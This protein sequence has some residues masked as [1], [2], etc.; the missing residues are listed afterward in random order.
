MRA[1]LTRVIGVAAVAATALLSVAGAASAATHP[2][3]KTPTTLSIVEAKTTINQG[4]TDL[5]KGTLL[6]G[7]KPV[8]G[9]VVYLDRYSSS[10]KKWEAVAVDLTG[11]LGKVE[12]TV[13]PSS[14]A[15]FELVFKGTSSLAASHS[16]VATVLVVRMST[17]L[18]ASEAAA[19]IEPGQTDV[20]TG[21][22]LSGST[23][24][25]G[26]NVRI[27]RYDG[28]DHKWVLHAIG[29]T[30][31]TG[32]VAFTVAPGAT[33]YYQLVFE[34]TG[35]L[36]ASHSG[37]VTVL[38]I[39]LPTTLSIA[40][41]TNSIT[42][43]QHDVISGEL[44]TGPTAVPGKVIYLY[45]YSTSAKKW[46]AVEAELTNSGGQVAFS[47]KP[48]STTSYKLEFHGGA[49]LDSSASGDAVVTVVN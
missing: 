9:R 33:D 1:S 34:G 26:V 14:T 30:G 5:I 41:A 2:S 40:A 3:A 8:A 32:T 49:S 28:S 18:S 7:T 19:V 39:K 45:R 42:A 27:Y 17:T 25:A 20:I 11:K 31:S 15:S 21:A 16:G 35:T 13:K 24:V 38:V 44:Q 6:T 37:V 36:G 12:F 46:E 22:L 48:S 43:G 23:P 4:E 29:E 10:A 47:V